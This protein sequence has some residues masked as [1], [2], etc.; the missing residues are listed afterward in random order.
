[1]TR[2]LW[3]S[4]DVLE[5]PEEGRLSS[6]VSWVQSP[7]APGCPRIGPGCSHVTTNSPAPHPH[8]QLSA[9]N[10]FPKGLRL[11]RPRRAGEDVGGRQGLSLGGAWPGKQP[12][13]YVSGCSLADWPLDLGLSPWES[14]PSM[15][16]I[17]FW[18][19]ARFL[20]MLTFRQKKAF[21]RILNPLRDPPLLLWACHSARLSPRLK[22]FPFGLLNSKWA[23]IS[24]AQNLLGCDSGTFSH[25]FFEHCELGACVLSHHV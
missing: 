25:T 10:N 20:F 14:A 13:S 4:R 9:T 12:A 22:I 15:L 24:D 17:Y 7:Q 21:W 6:S 11:W 19:H 16:S 3:F 2:T 8:S 23:E 1:M 18:L 5:P